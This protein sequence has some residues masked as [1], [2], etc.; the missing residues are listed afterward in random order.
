[1]PERAIF[2]V[3]IFFGAIFTFQQI[4]LG[5]RETFRGTVWG[6]GPFFV[7]SVDALRR[8]LGR[9]TATFSKK[10]PHWSGVYA[11]KRAIFHQKIARLPFLKVNTGVFY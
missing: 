1:M 10:T 8:A 7:M 5:R 2:G 11:T 4:L 6:D 9:D 3:K